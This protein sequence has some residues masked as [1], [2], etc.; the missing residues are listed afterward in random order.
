[1]T[2]N[3][4]PLFFMGNSGSLGSQDKPFTGVLHIDHPGFEK[5]LDQLPPTPANT[6]TVDM[7]W[8]GGAFVLFAYRHG[9]H[10]LVAISN[11]LYVF[12]VGRGD[13]RY[14]FEKVVV[15]L[16]QVG[17]HLVTQRMTT[18]NS[19]AIITS[20]RS[21]QIYTVELERLLADAK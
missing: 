17:N 4:L 18:H 13:G 10:L 3:F 16:D 1:M 14:R 8:P 21:G 20:G 9:D 5:E 6:S 7:S 19:K 2:Y 11:K 15:L 12:D